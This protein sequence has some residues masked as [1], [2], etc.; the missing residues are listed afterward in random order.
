MCRLSMRMF[1]MQN[2]GVKTLKSTRMPQW[3]VKLVAKT[4]QFP[5]QLQRQCNFLYRK[6]NCTVFATEF[7][8]RLSMHVF[9]IQNPGVKTLKNTVNARMPK[10]R[11]KLVA[12]TMQFPVYCTV[13]VI[14]CNAHYKLCIFSLYKSILMIFST[15]SYKSLKLINWKYWKIPFTNSMLGYKE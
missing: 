10:R 13:H 12:K 9:W 7:M 1:W 5:V 15:W 11:A 8:R 14:K 6:L 4:M 3:R 2:S